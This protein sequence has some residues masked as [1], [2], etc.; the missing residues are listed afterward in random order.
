MS[1]G[2][3]VPLVSESLLPAISM[4]PLPSVNSHFL[5]TQQH[6]TQN[7]HENAHRII[8]LEPIYN[9]KGLP[10]ANTVT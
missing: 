7:K 1:T 6:S 5:H 2:E 4:C 3:N 8:L 9:M 10:F